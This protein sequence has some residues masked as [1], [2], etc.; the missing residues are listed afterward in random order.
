[1][2]FAWVQSLWTRF[3]HV[4]VRAE[5]LALLRVLLGVFLLTDQLYQYLPYLAEFYG[6]H[7]VSPDGLHDWYALKKWYWTLLFF[8]TDNLT[9]IRVVFGLWM[10]VT[11][12][13][14]IG[15][16]TRLMNVFLW[17]LTQCFLNRNLDILN[18]GDYILLLTIFLLMFA[19]S[20]RAFSLDALRR[21][22]AGALPQPNLIPA[23]PVRVLQLQMCMIYCTS[24]LVKLQGDGPFR[25]TW[26]DGSSVHYVLNNLLMSRV[27]YVQLPIPYWITAAMTYV[28]VWWEV[29]FPM[30]LSRKTRRWA[31]WFGVLFHLGILFS[32]EIG[33]FSFYSLMLYAVWI[34][35]E[36][37]TRR[38]GAKED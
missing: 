1:M 18:G 17:V 37:W 9:A 21:R 30:V 13:F 5:R 34:P 36:F 12:A 3:W 14:T 19:P 26:W 11:F 4:P 20:G 22:R 6:P 15:W 24:G 32:I 31:L 38:Q 27:S 35:D 7:G 8:H 28:C 10:A 2:A 25:G 23:W 29:L 16:H 33:W